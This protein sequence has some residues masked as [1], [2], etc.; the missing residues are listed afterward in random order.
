MRSVRLVLSWELTASLYCHFSG[1]KGHFICTAS[2]T[3]RDSSAHRAPAG[4]IWSVNAAPS[5]Q[6]EAPLQN[7]F[8]YD[9]WISTSH[10]THDSLQYM[11]APSN[12]CQCTQKTGWKQRPLLAYFW[13]CG[14]SASPLRWLGAAVLTALPLQ[15]TPPARLLSPGCPWSV[16]N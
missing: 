8:K 3:S 6:D 9:I 14:D 2:W 16:G 15:G 12:P 13:Y 4:E 11:V 5:T 1:T 7:I 10:K